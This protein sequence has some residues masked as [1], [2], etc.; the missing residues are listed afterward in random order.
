MDEPW[1]LPLELV[2]GL[3]ALCG[4]L[5]AGFLFRRSWL[6][7]RPGAFECSVRLGVGGWQIG[8][9][10]YRAE[11]LAWYS[12]F[13]FSLQA[14]YVWPR[15]GLELR[16]INREPKGGAALL[17]DS[18]VA[19]CAVASGTVELAMQDRVLTGFSSWL[20]SSPPGFRGVH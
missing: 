14:R 11:A 20:E 7:R 2:A 4:L 8:I 19:E 1:V 5:F 18:V 3:V 10:E 12:L 17:P 13:S 9:A 6:L 15:R 16:G